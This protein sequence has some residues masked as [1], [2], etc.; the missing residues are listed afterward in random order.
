M[1]GDLG[2]IE[3]I[4]ISS[5]TGF[6]H[7]TFRRTINIQCKENGELFT[8]AS[9]QVDNGPNS[10]VINAASLDEFNIDVNEA[11]FVKNKMLFISNKL[12]IVIDKAD[13]W[14]SILPEYPSNTQNVIRNIKKMKEYIDNHGKAG[15]MKKKLSSQSPYE[16]ELSRLLEERTIL[17]EKEL[18]NNR[19]AHAL[20]HAVSLIGLGPGLTP[21][22][23]D[24]L[25]GLF[26]TINLRNSPLYSQQS[27]C[28]EV[29][30]RAKPLTNEISYM[31]L[32]KASIGKVRE[33]IIHLVHSIL[34]GKES[35]LYL[36]LNKVL[37]IGS[38]SGT[39]IALGL[40][41]GLEANLRVGGQL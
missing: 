38:S 17:L 36:S 37:N 12:A 9:S 19:L 7:S 16:T 15:G 10:L 24:F 27:F 41:C 4:N 18:L 25:V 34:Y 5:L 21:S 28:E 6:V 13:K 40:I 32:K 26:T 11:V 31:A 14:E 22:G 2:F 23:D 29:V 30:Q 3:R 39:D 33:S 35:D 8:I 20:Q 1:S